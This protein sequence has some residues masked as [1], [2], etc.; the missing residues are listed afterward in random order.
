MRKFL[1]T[2]FVKA[3]ARYPV[4]TGAIMHK[5]VAAASSGSKKSR[6]SDSS[7]GEAPERISGLAAA[8]RA[9]GIAVDSEAELT[10]FNGVLAANAAAGIPGYEGLRG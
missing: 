4:A 1:D 7:A 9:A 10:R 5:V 2:V 8:N 3:Q 6:G